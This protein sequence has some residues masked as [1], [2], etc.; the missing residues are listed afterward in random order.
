MESPAS[1]KTYND[2]EDVRYDDEEDNSNDSIKYISDNSNNEIQNEICNRENQWY[3]FYEL[4]VFL[5]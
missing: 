5:K 2:N 1:V 4:N 3:D